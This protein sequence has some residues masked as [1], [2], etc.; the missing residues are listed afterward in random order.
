MKS[1]LHLLAMAAHDNYVVDFQAFKTLDNYFII[2]ELCIVNVDKNYYI[3]VM[4]KPYTSYANL[5]NNEF[6]KRINFLTNN[7]HGILWNSGYVNEEVAIDLLRN[8]LKNAR[9]VYIKGS[10]RVEFLRDVLYQY[11]VRVKDLD[12]FNFRGIDEMEFPCCNYTYRHC[13]LRCA[14]RKALAYAY[15]LQM[16]K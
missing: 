1:V 16:N 12:I 7:V 13:Q 8:N 6:K 3:H 2:K 10:E 14:K 11:D 4:V 15:W 9:T 5:H